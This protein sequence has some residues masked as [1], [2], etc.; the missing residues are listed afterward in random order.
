M[1][2][3]APDAA[4]ADRGEGRALAAGLGRGQQGRDALG[5]VTHRADDVADGADPLHPL[6]IDVQGVVHG[7]VDELEGVAEPELLHGLCREGDLD[8]QPCGSGELAGRPGS[9]ARTELAQEVAAGDPEDLLE[10]GDGLERTH[11]L[12]LAATGLPVAQRRDAD[13]GAAL[14]EA[15]TQRLEAAPA[16]LDGRAQGSREGG[17][18]ESLGA[19][20]APVLRRRHS[21]TSPAGTSAPPRRSPALRPTR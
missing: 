10:V 14:V 18:V 12:G 7:E 11:A 6:G 19:P 17:I 8:G 16:A 21:Q 2:D 20:L 13:R 9:A 15:A 3:R 1:G 5:A 4:A